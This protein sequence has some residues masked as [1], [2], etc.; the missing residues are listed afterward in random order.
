MPAYQITCPRC[1]HTWMDQIEPPKRT[2][3]PTPPPTDLDKEVA[4]LF[5]S[6]PPWRSFKVSVAAVRKALGGRLAGGHAGKDL[7]RALENN[8]F[9]MY[10][11]NG[12]MVAVMG[13]RLDAEEFDLSA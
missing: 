2:F 7:R 6:A 4:K 5:V 1:N 8:G 3:A 9:K 10:K 11:S 12:C 13:N